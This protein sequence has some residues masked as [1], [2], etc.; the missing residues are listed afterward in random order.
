MASK[1]QIPIAFKSD[2]RG[3]K[4]A[5]SALSGFG[6]KLA[7]IGVAVAGA[8]AINKIVD[9][10]KASVNSASSLQE[11]LNAVVVSY[12]EASA[13]VV[14]LGEDAAQR[15]GVTQ[16]AF[17]EAAV[18]YSAFA[19]RIVGK[20]G[21][22]AD[23]IDDITT[24]AADFASVFN[25]EVSEALQIFQSGLSG[26]AEPL[27]R[28]GINLLQSEVQAYALR[29]GLIAVGEQMTE[30]QKI[31]ARYG[32]LM[33]STAKTVGDFANTSDSL[34]NSQR[35][36]QASFETIQATIGMALLP[37]FEKLTKYILEELVPPVTAFFQDDFPRILESL[38]PI[39]QGAVGF[40]EKI[41]A[42]IRDAFDI[43]L[44]NS[45]LEHFLNQLS[46][47][48]A[49]PDFVA[50]METIVELFET[51]LPD[52]TEA[53]FQFGELAATLVPI[54]LDAI[55]EIIP[56]I[57]DMASILNDIGYFLNEIINQFV[58]WEGDS[59]AIIDFI[60][61]QIN[62]ME[63]LQHAA[64]LLAEALRFAREQWERFTASGASLPSQEV[65]GG[66]RFARAVGG[67]VSAMS[68]YMVGER[69]PELFTPGAG[70]FITP[71]NRLGGGSS[72][73][74]TINVTAGMGANGNQ[75][76][77]EIIRQIKRYERASGPVFASA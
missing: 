5:E 76:G 53:V 41:G 6:K 66:R 47:L 74:I 50:F 61:R 24:R 65:T 52:L 25:I 7:G 13:A 30:D 34:A 77:E 31:V 49:N 62:P 15:L 60:N 55:K 19:E 27:K 71:N 32:L 59:N 10:T 73:N 67:P 46:G 12:G 48:S 20:G 23:F 75:I 56:F 38:G 16:T 54:V 64:Q 3:I 63:R 8:F 42:V 35:I 11:S 40:F 29:E 70:G 72:T 45:I 21:N 37:T 18:R 33:E 43:D 9:F 39:V 17:N 68:S 4:E 58:V 51:L 69:G 44:E 14:K 36:L 2:P 1:F 22:V 28:F 57:R 26:E